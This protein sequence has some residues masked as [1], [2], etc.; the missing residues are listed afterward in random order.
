MTHFL[1]ESNISYLKYICQFSTPSQFWSDLDHEIYPLTR[2]WFMDLDTILEADTPLNDLNDR[3]IGYYKQLSRPISSHPF[4]LRT[5]T[6]TAGEGDIRCIELQAEKVMRPD[7]LM[8][9]NTTLKKVKLGDSYIYETFDDDD[10]SHFQRSLINGKFS[11]RKVKV[12]EPKMIDPECN[13]MYKPVVRVGRGQVLNEYDERCDYRPKEDRA[14]PKPDSDIEDWQ[15]KRTPEMQ[16]S[17]DKL[18]VETRTPIIPQYHSTG[19]KCIPNSEFDIRNASKIMQDHLEKDYRP[20][21]RAYIDKLRRTEM[22][23]QPKVTPCKNSQSILDQIAM[24]KIRYNDI[25]MNGNRQMM[26]KGY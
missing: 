24:R 3:F 10:I 18:K 17:L 5:N 1:S 15:Y 22:A 12:E 11:R 19:N 16:A 8:S 20:N 6:T 23:R 9:V 14:R 21:S 7:N 13:G 25:R 2:K 26:N 4:R